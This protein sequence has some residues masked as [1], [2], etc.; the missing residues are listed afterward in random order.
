MLDNM[1]THIP[2]VKS[3][4]VKPLA[5]TAAT[6]IEI[7][8]DVPTVAEP[9]YP[10]FVAGTL[11]GLVAPAKTPTEIV[12]RLQVAIA[13]ILAMSEVRNPLIRLGLQPVGG[14]PA[15]FSKFMQDEYGK[16]GKIVKVAN[17]KVE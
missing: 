16:A 6:R 17:V 7:L 15:Q 1:V 4:K 9:G 10:G 12:D 3:V 13:R 11:Y 8:S 2:H 14:T 5:G